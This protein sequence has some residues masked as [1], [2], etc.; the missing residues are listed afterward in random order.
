MLCIPYKNTTYL[1]YVRIHKLSIL[2]FYFEQSSLS[3]SL[4][5]LSCFTL[6]ISSENN[7]ITWGISTKS[8]P[9]L[10]SFPPLIIDEPDG[11]LVLQFEMQ[12]V[13]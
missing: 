4:C 11:Q 13:F 10:P 1:L 2:S 3:N 6:K 12:I 9:K 7:R 5:H 8:E